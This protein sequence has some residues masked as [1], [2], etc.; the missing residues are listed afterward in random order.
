MPTMKIN[1]SDCDS[2]I[3]KDQMDFYKP[4]QQELDDLLEYNYKHDKQIIFTLFT[5]YYRVAGR[6]LWE[7]YKVDKK[8]ITAYKLKQI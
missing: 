1:P 6:Q 2:S 3:V 4:S 8:L 5:Y 7:D